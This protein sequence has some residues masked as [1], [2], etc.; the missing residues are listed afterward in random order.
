MISR[1]SSREFSE[2]CFEQETPVIVVDALDAWGFTERWSP[3][4]LVNLAK[5]RRVTVSKAEGG[6]FYY[7]EARDLKEARKYVHQEM[8][9][10]EAVEH[11]MTSETE[12]KLYLMG[13]PIPD[14]LP[15]LVS[16]LV[17][18]QWIQSKDPHIT[19]W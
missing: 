2:A 1:M 16:N 19:L 4:Y 6:R 8:T 7:T 3:T 18:P 13:L 14:T 15:E 11:L 5:G 17:V 9:L 12:E 10:G